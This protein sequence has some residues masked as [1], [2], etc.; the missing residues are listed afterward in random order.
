MAGTCANLKAVAILTGLQTGYKKKSCAVSTCVFS[1][2]VTAM[3]T[4]KHFIRNEWSARTQATLG[5]YNIKN[6]SLVDP[7]KISCH[8]CTSSLV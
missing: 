7:N 1:A 4:K 2:Y 5:R 6:M 8:H 3:M